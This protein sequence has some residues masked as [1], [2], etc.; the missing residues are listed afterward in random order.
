MFILGKTAGF[1][2]IVI[3]KFGYVP[4]TRTQILQIRERSVDN[5]ILKA[6]EEADNA[7]E[8]I[9]EL[10]HMLNVDQWTDCCRSEIEL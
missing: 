9:A 2:A 3:P 8:T 7:Q 4:L 5:D 1:Y 6:I 10:F